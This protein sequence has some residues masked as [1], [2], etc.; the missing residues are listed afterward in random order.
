MSRLADLNSHSLLR[1]SPPLQMSNCVHVTGKSR[2]VPF[3]FSRLWATPRAGQCISISR[4]RCAL[5]TV[6]MPRGGTGGV[7]SVDKGNQYTR[8]STQTQGSRAKAD[9]PGAAGILTLKTNA[10]SP[11]SLSSKNSLFVLQDLRLSW[12]HPEKI[13]ISPIPPQS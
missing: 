13:R 7:W 11:K 8:S 6:I 10:H 3:P 2:P 12:E 1:G 4:P 5:Y 9:H